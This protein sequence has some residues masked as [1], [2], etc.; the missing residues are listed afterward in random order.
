MDAERVVL[1]F[2]QAINDHDLRGLTDMMTDDHQLITRTED[3]LVGR[4]A[5][6]LAWRRF[7][8]MFPDYRNEFRQVWSEGC[9]VWVRGHAACEDER[10]RGRAAWRAVVEG[11]MVREWRVDED[12]PEGWRRLGVKVVEADPPP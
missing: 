8:E 2:N 12:T 3:A 9:V 5:C 11:E 6:T 7:F 10:L 1:R 4:K